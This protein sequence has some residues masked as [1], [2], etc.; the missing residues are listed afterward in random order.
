MVVWWDGEDECLLGVVRRGGE[1]RVQIY[2]YRFSK[3]VS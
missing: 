2:I 3:P 1:V